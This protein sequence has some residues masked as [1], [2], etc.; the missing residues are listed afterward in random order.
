VSE[1]AQPARFR[2]PILAPRAQALA[3]AI[4][5]IVIYFLT[6]IA[7]VYRVG[8][9]SDDGVYAVLGKALA[10]GLGYHSIHLVGAPV[11][12]KYPPGFPFILSLLWR[13]GGSVEA[14]QHLVYVLHPVV[15]GAAAGL[16]WWLG[17]ARL[18]A[19]PALLALLVALPLLLE[20]SIEYY[21]LVLSEPWFILGWAGV[22][23]LWVNA[24]EC[25]PGRTRLLLFAAAGAL[26][27]ATTLVRVQAIMLLPAVT[28]AL[29]VRR[30]S[31]VERL[32]V[33]W[34]ILAPLGLWH[35][36]HSALIASGPVSRLP[37]EGPYIE[38]VRGTG[39]SLPALLAGV[40]SNA[41][42]YMTQFGDYLSSV[43]AFGKLEAALILVGGAASTAF[44]ARRQPVLA[45]SAAG[46]LAIILVWPFAQD[47]LL[48]PL[49]PFIGL[50]ACSAL[51]PA[52]QRAPPPT[53]RGIS[54]IAAVLV[55]MALIRQPEVRREGVAAVVEN[56]HPEFFT[57]GWLLL[58]NSRYIA[59]ASHWVRVNTS[60]T[61]RV[62]IDK[63]AGIFLYSG[64]V[65]VPGTMPESPLVRSVF[66]TPGRYLAS[67]ILEDSVDYVIIGLRNPGIMGD[68]ETVNLQCP[69]V[70]TWGG[71]T[72]RD[73]K[74]IFKV[75]RDE[76]CLRGLVRE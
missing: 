36:Y 37:D 43:P 58:L 59:A 6:S 57:P 19:P 5:V 3:V 1:P 75:R 64:R 61:A 22:L 38:W 52:Y 39:A 8:A 30:H 40:V 42:F 11:Q 68:I 65:T 73:S 56:R 45:L 69:G 7:D 48:L 17:R 13:I 26:V 44:A 62:M 51:S 18:A 60:P 24:A 20:A 50:A 47:R 35:L 49:L 66:S 54:L 4:G 25:P 53:R 27:S 2:W 32:L 14:V 46:G 9:W 76:N 70:L 67:R 41:A 21:T 29:L 72:P 10:E 23:V 31:L 55:A 28:V 12:V 63:H 15:I 74:F 16:V 71:T 33:A 34:M